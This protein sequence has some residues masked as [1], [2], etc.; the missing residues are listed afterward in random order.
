MGAFNDAI[1]AHQLV[2][3]PRFGE[4]PDGNRVQRIQLLG[5]DVQTFKRPRSPFWYAQTTVVGMQ[6]TTS[7]KQENQ[8]AAEEMAK[9]WYLGLIGKAVNGEL[10]SERT[11][12]AAAKKFMA[13][14]E[15][16]TQGQRSQKWVEGIGGGSGCI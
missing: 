11:F 4:L 3:W 5:G 13:E 14:Y 12:A 1:G 8:K 7:T 2:Q 10:S 16:I 9:A 6:R 15:T